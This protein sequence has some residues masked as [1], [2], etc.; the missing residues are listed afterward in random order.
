[1]PHAGLIPSNIS[2]EEELL[3]RAK[4]H[5]R[6]GRIRQQRGEYADAVAAFYDAL[7]SALLR[8]FVSDELREGYGL[9]TPNGEI[10]EIEHLRILVEHNI[11][12]TD[13]GISEM[14]ELKSMLGRAFEGKPVRPLEEE[15][16]AK[17][18][19]IM[20]QLQ[21]LPIHDDELPR[22]LSETT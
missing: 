5:V 17:Y 10:D 15:F 8:L 7:S 12:D 1:M 6:A 16:M 20:R 19:S 14:D 4:L 2:E 21:I 13:F 22:E 3:L 11:I 9:P 18:E